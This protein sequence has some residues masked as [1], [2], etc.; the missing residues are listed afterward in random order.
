ML[1]KISDAYYLII[2]MN[3]QRGAYASRLQCLKEVINFNVQNNRSCKLQVT[4]LHTKTGYWH[5]IYFDNRVKDILL[6]ISPAGSVVKGI[7]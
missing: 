4:D 3:T 1:S 2:V 6:H 7:T 5:D